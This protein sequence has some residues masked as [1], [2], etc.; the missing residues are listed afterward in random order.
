M[1]F[2][3]QVVASF[4]ASI[5]V[6]SEEAELFRGAAPESAHKVFGIENGVDFEHF[7]PEWHY[8]DLFGGER[9]VLVFTEA[10]NYW[11]NVDAVTWSANQVLPQVREHVPAAQLMI[12]GSNPAADVTAREPLPGV[13]VTGRVADIRSY[14]AHA[15]AAVAPLGIGP[16]GVQNKVL[17]SMAMAKPVIATPLSLEGI[18]AKANGEVVIAAT[19]ESLAAP[20]ITTLPGSA[21]GLI[22]QRA[23]AWVVADYAWP[24]RLASLEAVLEGR[25]PE[26]SVP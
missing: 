26:V 4:D 22:G 2:D 3:R 18:R 9:F 13:T 20:S 17:E 19:D 25:H 16:G 24:P 12:V 8:D 1:S 6:S 5:F 21:H 11:P 23:R 15:V 14:L 7:A 10:M